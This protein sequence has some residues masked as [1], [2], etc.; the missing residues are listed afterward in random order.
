MS[1]FFSINILLNDQ[2]LFFCEVGT[3]FVIIILL[4]RVFQRLTDSVVLI[5]LKTECG[6]SGSAFVHKVSGIEVIHER[7][8]DHAK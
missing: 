7:V 8:I 2:D 4:R 3:E 6:Q 5:G 1:L